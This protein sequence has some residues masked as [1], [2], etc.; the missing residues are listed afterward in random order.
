MWGAVNFYS[1]SIYFMT[2]EHP[3]V[4]EFHIKGKWRCCSTERHVYSAAGLGHPMGA[5]WGR[6]IYN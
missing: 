6:S 2:W 4:Q 1:T 3:G 5:G